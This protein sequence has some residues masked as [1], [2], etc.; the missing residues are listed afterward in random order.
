M[1]PI[2]IRSDISAKH[3]LCQGMYYEELDK[4]LDAPY[5][6]NRRIWRLSEINAVLSSE[7]EQVMTCSAFRFV[8][9]DSAVAGLTNRW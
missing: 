9:A 3:K 8:E 7:F 6:H 5:A 4:T 1:Y 2:T